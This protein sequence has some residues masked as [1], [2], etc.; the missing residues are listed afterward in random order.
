MDWVNLHP[1]FM[2]CL[3]FLEF[4]KWYNLTQLYSETAFLM[5]GKINW[6]TSTIIP[7]FAFIGPVDVN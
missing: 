7:A 6:D 2:N 3:S 5:T 1:N 4:S